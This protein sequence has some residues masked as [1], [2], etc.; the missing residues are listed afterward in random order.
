MYNL[1]DHRRNIIYKQKYYFSLLKR[2]EYG[3]IFILCEINHRSR[4]IHFKTFF[5]VNCLLNIEI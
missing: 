1:L 5:Y 2:Q 4:L 3:R